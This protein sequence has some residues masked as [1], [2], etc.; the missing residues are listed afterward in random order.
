VSIPSKVP[1]I[2]ILSWFG[3][4]LGLDSCPV[5]YVRH[6]TLKK[7][8]PGGCPMFTIFCSCLHPSEY[9]IDHAFM[10]PLSMFV[11]IWFEC[12]FSY[13]LSQVVLN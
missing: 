1:L 11:M 13:M 7:A 4:K 5:R 3:D 10:L 8:L 12:M 6:L 2:Q 9:K